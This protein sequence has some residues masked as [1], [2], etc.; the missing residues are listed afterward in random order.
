[1]YLTRQTWHFLNNQEWFWTCHL[2]ASTFQVVGLQMCMYHLVPLSSN[3]GDWTQDFLQAI[4]HCVNIFRSFSVYLLASLRMKSSWGRKK[5]RSA[6]QK[7]MITWESQHWSPVP[8]RNLVGPS[9]VFPL[10]SE[11]HP[12]GNSS[13]QFVCSALWHRIQAVANFWTSVVCRF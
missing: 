9:C 7:N 1:M 13:E 5:Q 8:A 11:I 2:H 12:L 6:V 4:L 3:A 10:G